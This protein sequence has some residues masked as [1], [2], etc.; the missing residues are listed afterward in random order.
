MDSNHEIEVIDEDKT[1]KEEKKDKKENLIKYGK[2]LR[3]CL[4]L[5]NMAY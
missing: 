1:V 4:M 5:L 3:L 2:L